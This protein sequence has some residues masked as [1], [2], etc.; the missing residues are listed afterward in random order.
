MRKVNFFVFYKKIMYEYIYDNVII[1]ILFYK[2]WITKIFFITIK[3]IYIYILW[4]TLI[5]FIKYHPII[6]IDIIIDQIP[7]LLFRLLYDLFF[8][9]DHYFYI[10]N[11]FCKTYS[12]SHYDLF[13]KI[14]ECNNQH[15]FRK[16]FFLINYIVCCFGH[17]VNLILMIPMKMMFVIFFLIHCIFSSIWIF[18]CIHRLFYITLS[19]F[20]IIYT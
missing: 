6:T 14:I 19:F 7:C 1:I 20:I 5:F 8:D 12:Q 10:H 3:H 18:L 17:Y 16:C 11:I 9:N 4:L 15:D 2:I 13:L